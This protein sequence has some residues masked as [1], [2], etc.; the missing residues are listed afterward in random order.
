VVSRGDSPPEDIG[1]P[2]DDAEYDEDEVIQHA[3]GG[4]GLDSVGAMHGDGLEMTPG[5]DEEDED[6]GADRDD[7]N[8][9]DQRDRDFGPD[10]GNMGGRDDVRAPWVISTIRVMSGFR[11]II[12]TAV[13]CSCQLEDIVCNAMWGLQGNR[14]YSFVL[15]HLRRVATT[16]SFPR[17]FVCSQGVFCSQAC[18]AQQGPMGLSCKA[19]RVVRA[20]MRMCRM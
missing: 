5:L 16:I 2:G 12:D 20:C 9:A 11:R 4:D 7:Y 18:P 10:S 1:D 17:S 19:P 3:G 13:D 15:R 8:P 6:E 14:A